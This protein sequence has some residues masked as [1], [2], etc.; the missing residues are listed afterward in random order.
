MATRDYIPGSELGKMEWLG[1]FVPWMSVY[2]AGH[3]FTAAEISELEVLR[4][5][6]DTAVSDDA[7]AQA[8]ARASTGT[9]RIGIAAAINLSRDYAQRLQTDP[10]MTDPERLAAGITVRDATKTATDPEDI[11]E[12]TPP[13]T[14]LDFSVRRQ[15]TIHWGPNPQD[16]SHNGRPAGVIGA[17]IQYCVGGIPEQEAGWITLDVDNHS[18]FVH[19]VHEDTSTTYAYRVCY[20]DKL[21]KRGPY[22]NPAIC[23]VSV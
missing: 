8:A 2:G 9:K 4:G 11:L 14:F 12:I 16:E 5:D 7:I 21:L 15:I 19:T 1:V 18:P 3:G 17:Q 6:A 22:G 10:T 13:L 20:V 23:T